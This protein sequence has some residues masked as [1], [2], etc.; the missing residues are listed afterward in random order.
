MWSIKFL[1]MFAFKFALYNL[2]FAIE[3]IECNWI[4][5]TTLKL[6]LKLNAYQFKYKEYVK[7]LLLLYYFTH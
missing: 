2:K 1:Y 7:I 5:H 6:F 4:Y 3:F